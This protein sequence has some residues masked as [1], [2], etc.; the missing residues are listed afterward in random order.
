MS[1]HS[2]C[3]AKTVRKVKISQLFI[4][5]IALPTPTIGNYHNLSRKTGNIIWTI[6]LLAKLKFLSS[7]WKIPQNFLVTKAPGPLL[8]NEDPSSSPIVMWINS[9]CNY[10]TYLVSLSSKKG[11]KG[12]DFPS[13]NRGRKKDTGVWVSTYV[14]TISILFYSV[15]FKIVIS[16]EVIALK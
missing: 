2:D 7:I 11:Y 16:W 13:T 4:P 3:W 1:K 8:K 9:T 6:C 12:K 10:L 15:I 5:S 14:L